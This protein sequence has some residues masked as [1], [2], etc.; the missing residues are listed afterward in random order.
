[1]SYQPSSYGEACHVCQGVVPP[2]YNLE[3]WA[4]HGL[5]MDFCT[6]ENQANLFLLI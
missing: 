5:L 4:S 1:M 3:S 2:Q 6:G